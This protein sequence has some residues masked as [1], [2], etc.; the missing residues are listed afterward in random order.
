M[1]PVK[2]GVVFDERIHY[3]T[4][5]GEVGNHA[6]LFVDDDLSVQ[7][8]V[9]G[10]VAVVDHPATVDDQPRGVALAVGAGIGRVGWHPVVGDKLVVE[11]VGVRRMENNDASTRAFNGSDDVF[12]AAHK[13]QVMVLIVVQVDFDRVGQNR[14]VGVLGVFLAAAQEGSCAY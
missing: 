2:G 10:V 4:V 1:G 7:D 13:P 12:P 11:I 3:R 6:K 9:V 5:G 14:P 8:V